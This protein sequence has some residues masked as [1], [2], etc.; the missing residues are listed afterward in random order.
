L[1]TF[2]ASAYLVL[3]SLFLATTLTFSFFTSAASALTFLGFS[4]FLGFAAALGVLTSFF[5]SFLVAK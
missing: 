4:S 2:L 3:L 5:S 1:T